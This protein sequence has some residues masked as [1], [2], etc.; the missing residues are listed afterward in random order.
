MLQL[1]LFRAVQ[2][3]PAAG[4]L[5]LLS[6]TIIADLVAPRER[7]RYQGYIGSVFA[8]SSIAGPVMGGV[9]VDQLV[10][11]LGVPD[12]TCRWARVAPA[13]HLAAARPAGAGPK[14]AV[15]A[16]TMA[17]AGLIMSAQLVAACWC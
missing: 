9:F 10:L 2:G 15:T 3:R 6:Q 7:G 4:G 13:R 14:P 16:S 1:I 17:G 5:M 8:T 12:Q 11:A